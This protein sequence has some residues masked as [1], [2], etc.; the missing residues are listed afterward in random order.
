MHAEIRIR[1]RAR[2][3]FRRAGQQ[4]L[5]GIRH[6]QPDIV[7]DPSLHAEHTEG[8]RHIAGNKYLF[9]PQAAFLNDNS[10]H[11]R[12][13]TQ[14]VGHLQRQVRPGR[15]LPAHTGADKMRAIPRHHAP[16]RNGFQH[17]T[18]RAGRRAP[19]RVRRAVHRTQPQPVQEQRAVRAARVEFQVV[20]ACHGGWQRSLY[21]QQLP[22]AS[23]VFPPVQGDRLLRF[24][25]AQVEGYHCTGGF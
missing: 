3:R 19:C 25:I 7:Y 12:C 20:M 17:H 10:R 11:R 5:T 15:G 18:C 13:L 8:L 22:F 21:S 24:I 2:Q 4:G 9:F 23:G 1:H 6:R 16:G 14:G